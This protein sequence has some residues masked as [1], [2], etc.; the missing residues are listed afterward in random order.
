[1]ANTVEKYDIPVG[2]SYSYTVLN[3][4]STKV[5]TIKPFGRDQVLGSIPYERIWVGDRNFDGEVVEPGDMDYGNAVLL[6]LKGEQGKYVYIGRR[7]ITIFEAGNIDT[8]YSMHDMSTK[9]YACD[10]NLVYF[11]QLQ[12]GRIVTFPRNILEGFEREYGSDDDY[13]AKINE[14]N[15]NENENENGEG[16][17]DGRQNLIRPIESQ[18]YFRYVQ[19]QNIL[20]KN[21]NVNKVQMLGNIT[22][23][24]I[25]NNIEGYIGTFLSGKNGTLLQQKRALQRNFNALQGGK[26][27]RRTRK[28]GKKVRRTRKGGKKVQR[29]HKK[30]YGRK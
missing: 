8:F 2:N 25:P 3:N 7:Q 1:M 9:S 11:F 4:T 13:Y 5:V 23:K 12:N 6:Q 21:R 28:G 26:K 10:E 14:I 20:K 30:H 22:G 24:P 15:E 17:N 19:Q 16:E 27:V 29:T 18:N